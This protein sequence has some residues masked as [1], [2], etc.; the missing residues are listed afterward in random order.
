MDDSGDT[1]PS[2]DD[3]RYPYVWFWVA[4]LPERKG[5][6]CRVV[7]RGGW[8]SVLVEFQDGFR[9]LTSRNAV[10]LYKP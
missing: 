1:S 8:N 3:D 9:V 5:Q 4:K 6:R 10:R 2:P 7:T